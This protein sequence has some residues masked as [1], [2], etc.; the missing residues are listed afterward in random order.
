MDY[1]AALTGQNQK[2]GELMR[3]TDW[4]VPVPTC[5]GGMVFVDPEGLRGDALRQWVDG[6]AAR[7]RR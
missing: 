6:R 5:P 4:P 2:L 3:D 7:K 1:A